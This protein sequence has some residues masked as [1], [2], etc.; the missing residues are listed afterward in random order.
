MLVLQVGDVPP[1]SGVPRTQF[2]MSRG[3]AAERDAARSFRQFLNETDRYLADTTFPYSAD[4]AGKQDVGEIRRRETLWDVLRMRLVP[5]EADDPGLLVGERSARAA[6][7]HAV[8]AYRDLSSTPRVETAHRLMHRYGEL[9]SGLYGCWMDWESGDGVWYDTCALVHAHSDYGVSVGFTTRRFCSI[10]RLDIS[11]CPHLSFQM[12]EVL[13]TRYDDESIGKCSVCHRNAC[14][15]AVGAK[16]QVYP[17]L[18]MD[19]PVMHEA[20]LTLDP[21][22]PRARIT[23]IEMDPQPARPKSSGARVR[24]RRCLHGCGG[25]RE[26]ARP[27]L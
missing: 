6:L 16:Y 8:D 1:P 7:D 3:R 23:A 24:C 25:I 9:V 27:V 5:T 14:E 10:C 12:Y 19:D 26:S 15:H 20:S 18:L 4:P 22:E 2:L 21:R 11:T 13:A 17:W